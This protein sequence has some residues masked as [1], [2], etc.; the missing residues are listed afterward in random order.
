MATATGARR[1]SFSE[2][3]AAYAV[4]RIQSKN[5]VVV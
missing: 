3:E 1:A 2:K 5:V 4:M